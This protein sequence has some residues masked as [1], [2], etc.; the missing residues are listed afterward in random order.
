MMAANLP[1][2]AL[3]SNKLA[4]GSVTAAALANG[5]V[6]Q[7]KLNFQLGYVNARNP[8]YGAKGDGVADDTAA[9]QS[10]LNDAGAGGG[11]IV[12]LPQGDYLILA[13][14]LV[15][16]QTTLAGIWRA[17]A[18]FHATPGHDVAGGGGGRQHLRCS[19]H[20]PPG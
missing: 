11:G 6:S 3:T 17:P 5:T 12:L 19:V 14:L 8:P 1:D 16:A 15:P 4:A 20:Y 2:G 10:A 7:S 18:A 9:I 13:H